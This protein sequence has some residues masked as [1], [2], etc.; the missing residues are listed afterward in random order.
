MLVRLLL[1]RRCDL[2]CIMST[3]RPARDRG[4]RIDSAHPRVPDRPNMAKRQRRG[5]SHEEKAILI[6]LCTAPYFFRTMASWPQRSPGHC[7]P[8]VQLGATAELLVL[9]AKEI[10]HVGVGH[11]RAPAA[12]QPDRVIWFGAN[13]ASM[14]ILLGGLEKKSFAWNLDRIHGSLLAGP[15]K[16][17]WAR[18]P[19]DA[20]VNP[21]I[22]RFPAIGLQSVSACSSHIMHHD[23][24]EDACMG[25]PLRHAY[26]VLQ[27][28]RALF[29]SQGC[30]QSRSCRVSEQWKVGY[31]RSNFCAADP[32]DSSP[33][34]SCLG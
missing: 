7:L 18:K 34:S 6:R 20:V 8:P 15:E 16:A 26:P 5:S 13:D 30:R 32:C 3:T 12:V 1:H 25:A 17:V 9:V 22:Q 4:V 10:S 33:H 28:F 14:P 11:S 21:T 27:R 24:D 2:F 23:V 19:D 29:F 31:M